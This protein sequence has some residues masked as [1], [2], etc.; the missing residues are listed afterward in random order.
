MPV[1]ALRVSYVGELGWE[2][3][4]SADVALRLWDVLIDA[5]AEHGIVPAGRGALDA[6]RIEKGY[7]S[8]GRD[9]TAEHSPGEA[10]LAFAVKPSKG[11]FVGSA[12]FERRGAPQRRLVPLVLD[13]DTRVPMGSEP[14]LVDG[15]PCGYVTS[16]AWLP[17][18]AVVA[19]YAWLPAAHAELG[20]RVEI[21]YFDAMLS[22]VVAREPLV[23]DSPG[24][25]SAAPAKAAA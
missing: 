21:G 2:L 10:G 6:L 7:R 5:G 8:W 16:A 18:A 3:Y 19:A 13:D 22:A 4:C 20:T 17:T 9:M 15:E 14:V 12:A 24:L 23:P 1:T 25:R 11:T